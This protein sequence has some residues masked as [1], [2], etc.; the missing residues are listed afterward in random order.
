MRRN[1]CRASRS[2][3]R[4]F[5]ATCVTL[6]AGLALQTDLYAFTVNVVGCDSAN[7]CNLPVS[8]FRWLLEEDNTNQ[9][10]PGVRVGDS[11]GLDIHNS[12]A[13]VVAKGNAAGGSTSITVPDSNKRY[14]LSV[15][16]DAGFS[17]SGTMVGA[18]ASAVTV[19]VHQNPLPTAQVSIFIFKDHNPINNTPDAGEEGI[20]GASIKIF[21][22]GGQMSQDAC[23]N[24]LGTTYSASD[25]SSVDV[26]GTGVI[27][28]DANGQAFIK[29]LVPGKY[30]IRAVPPGDAAGWTQT[31][32]IEGTPGIDAW[33][34]ANEPPLFIE[35]FGTGFNHVF[36]GFVKPEELPWAG[37]GPGGAT[38][39][40][41]NIFNHFGRPPTNQGFFEGPPVSGCWVGLNNLAAVNKGL[42]AVP[43][44]GESNFTIE[45]VPPG[46]YQLVT[47]DR[48]LDALFGF[49]TVTVPAGAGTIDL[50]NVMSFRWFGTLKGSVFF[51]VNQNGFRDEGEQGIANQAV[52]LRFRDGSV[53]QATT[54][55]PGGE[56]SLEEVFPF[57]K[58]LVAEV[59]YLRF[60]PTGMTA[61]VDYGGQIPPASGWIVPSFGALNPQPQVMVNPNTGNDLSRTETGP[62]LTQAMHL[63]LNQTNVIDWGKVNY[64]LNENG[65]ISGIVFYDVT[66]AENDPRMAAGEPWCPG[67]PRVQVCLYRDTDANGIIDDLNGVAGVQLCDVDNYPFGWSDNTA[68][69][70]P[71]DVVR[72]GD[73]TNFSLGDAIEL[74]TTDSW[75][76][77]K[78]TGCVQDLPPIAG[79]QPCYDNYGTWNQVRP[80]VFDGGYAFGS[81][82]GGALDPGTYIVEAVTPSGYETVKEEDKNVDFGDEFRPSQLL[83]PAVCVGTIENTGFDHVVPNW[84]T[85][86]DQQVA[87]DPPLA[88]SVTPLCSMK[89]VTVQPTQNTAADFFM[90]TEV[91]KAARVVGF[92]NNDLAA[93]FNAGSP[94]FGEKTSP[95]WLPVSMQ[96]WQGNEVARVYTDEWGSYNALLPSTFTANAAIPAGMSPNMITA[97]LNHPIMPDGTIDPFYDPR[98]SV[99][100]WTFDYWSGKTT[101]L[102]TPLVPVAS[103]TGFPQAG[104][105][106]EPATLVPVIASVTGSLTGPVVCGST[107]NIT[108]TSLGLTAVPN[109][110]FDPNIPGSPATV[111]RDYGF[112]SVQGSV[113]LNGVPL[114]VTA[115]SDA[116]ISATVPAGLAT[117]TLIVVRGD[118]GNAT[119]IGV[120]LHVV[121]SCTGVRQVVPGSP[122]AIQNTVDTAASGDLIIVPPGTYSEN[123]ILYKN[124]KLQGSGAG[125]TIIYAN[126]SPAN[127][128]SAWHD[129][130]LSILGTDPFLANEAPGIM[131][132]GTAPGFSNP[133]LIDGFKVFGAIMG[134]GIYVD[135][136]VTG[137]TISNNRLTG[138]QG[139]FGGGIAIGMPQRVSNNPNITIRNN[140]ITKNGGVQGG[141]GIAIYSGSTGYAVTDNLISGNFSR[142]NG[143][144]VAHTGLS[145]N[146]LIADNRITF[147]E[148]AFGGAAFGEGAGIFVGGEQVPGA[149]SAGAGNVAIRSN[150]IQGN[151]AGVGTGGG[152]RA[153]A[154]NGQDVLAAPGNPAAWYQLIIENNMIVNNVAGFAAGGIGLQDA[155]RVRIVN[156][157]IADNDSTATAANAFGAGA[158]TST[159]Q[160]AGIVSNAHSTGATGIAAASG[161]TFSDPV[162]VNNIVRNNRSFYTTNNG[163]GGLLPNP[164]M[165]VWDLS[166]TGVPTFLNPSN[167]LLTSL[168]PGDGANYTGNGNTAGNPA[169][170][171]SYFNQIVIA[172]VIDE[173]GN[174][175]TVRFTPL[176]ETAGDYHIR[177]ASSAVDAASAAA[178]PAT[179]YD[180]ENRP[181]GAG[182]DIGADEMY[183]AT[184][185]AGPVTGIGAVRNAEWFLDQNKNGTWDA[186][187]RTFVF[188]M[189]G[190]QPVSGDWTGSGTFKA[191]VFRNGTWYLDS[192]NNGFLDAGTDST[193]SF[194]V[195]GD[196][197]VTGDWNGGG[198][199]KIGVV[200]GNTWFLD[201][202]GNGAWDQGVDAV[203]S[204]GI[205]SDKPITGDWTGNGTTKIGVVRGNTWFLDM[206]GNGVWDNSIDAAYSFGIPGDVPVTGDWTGNGISKIGVVRG[207]G[208]WFLDMNGNGG[209]DGTDQT[210][211]GFGIPGDLPV[212][213][214]W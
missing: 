177:A 109:P 183:T 116:S 167:C 21:D 28:T 20:A 44:D 195:A 57:F 74:A 36:I 197:P 9:S 63:F 186:G 124:V 181:N 46:T 120:T 31:S 33:V 209:W 75:D 59:D 37:Q 185:P 133:T 7:N 86:F 161:Q 159:P 45:N 141:G 4:R 51:D 42:I 113:T 175:I 204:F 99:T 1:T 154:V 91:P 40:G 164:A 71:E 54:T 64:Q 198:T 143:G 206:N 131:V 132:L 166:V 117:G 27:L 165:P 189:P 193:F 2:R 196:R 201:M 211:S 149:A 39:K 125:S 192:N 43:C 212:T 89:Q 97:V 11:I 135:D 73:G 157:T 150:L 41:R 92:C 53:Y 203:Y 123:V 80:G 98:Y 111:T 3:F 72:S 145:N 32:T 35:G 87:I 69:K 16:P 207:G 79:V 148:V 82:A 12:H 15:L 122:N 140:E 8:G 19:K 173:G 158:T 25:C 172:A 199:T 17:I 121:A 114:P 10:P 139:N 208:T 205:P 184:V 30:G 105:D 147:N 151:L 55:V 160:G 178:A 108:I 24:P 101:Y 136:N 169:F 93:E 94:V 174:A 6:L 60:K 202:N 95:A 96:D 129:K 23:G 213:G 115:W 61:A 29:N 56:Y 102:D 162:L 127:K 144:G 191:G 107:R 194:G 180:G 66:R 34:K 83:L 210:I 70:G 78:P 13:P 106:V 85:L 176:T 156:N 100:P 155:A 112:G 88:G 26:M 119:E 38:I 62:V 128:L 65:G 48:P 130:I 84:L 152:I 47:W 170:V 214:K 200:R 134:G 14:F 187:D 179:D 118:N 168:T 182:P 49:N 110:D 76:D 58:W 190:D 137:L 67:I 138:N 52:N 146:G 188:G 163:V 126:P 50:G 104:P 68:P 142:F 153:F 77:N 18:G 5:F 81:P 171:N 22:L 90:F 103:F